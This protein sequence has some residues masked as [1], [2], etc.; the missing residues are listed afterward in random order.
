MP[1]FP[2]LQAGF[3]T[4]GKDFF[5][6]IQPTPLSD[7][8]LAAW[9]PALAAE[10]GLTAEAAGSDGTLAL[11]A[12]NAML[13]TPPA[14][15]TVYSG[16]QFGVWA[17]QLGDGRAILLG[18]WVD[19][20]GLGQEIQLKGAGRTPYSRRGD[21]RAVL[22]SSI[23][24]YL[25]SE[26]MHGLGIPT[27]RALALVASSE[28]VWR[29]QVEPA[30]VVTRVAPSF[31]RFGHF[32]HFYHAGRHAQ[33]QRLADYAIR[34]Y[35]PACLDADKPYQALLDTVIARTAELIAAWQAVGFCHGVMNSDN[36]SLLG[37][38]IDYGPFGFLDGFDA[39]HVCN[40]SDDHGR[41]RY[42]NQP[43]IGLFNL[44]CLAQALLPL[45]E[46]DAAVAALNGYQARFE[47]AHLARFR[48]KLGLATAEQADEVLL[49]G[50]FDLLQ[51]SRADWTIFWRRLGDFVSQPAAL[52]TALRDLFLDRAAFDAWAVDYRAR[53]QREASVDS[54]RQTRMRRIN[55]KY[56]LRNHLA[57][58]AIRAAH[59]GDFSEIE[60]L[61][62]LLARPY[63][64]QPE[65]ETYASFPPDWANALSVS[66]SS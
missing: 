66:C 1:P 6:P 60:S 40:H 7:I 5:S 48:E 62:R 54:E 24:E 38:T 21:G 39:N 18:E 64:E 19:K 30:A 2:L 34:R 27:T 63:D 33:L 36:M 51:A 56:V 49:N 26:A 53:L 31:L 61:R 15:T 28:E 3:H 22:R 4:L 32:E 37:L 58:Q 50:L 16:H 14:I 25:C 65:F 20:N 9:N 52:N 13:A 8:R 10:L 17:G 43:E 55:P 35:F 11:L 45:L 47:A 42:A 44:Q 59:T 12:G 29:E 41:Y 57:E 46:H 23:R